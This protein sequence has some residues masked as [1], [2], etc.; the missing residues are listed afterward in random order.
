MKYYGQNETD[1][2]IAEFINIE[3]PGNC[4]EV[5]V[6][7]GSHGS[8]TKI[9]EDK[10]WD[11]LCIDPVPEHVE[12]ARSIRKN[13]VQC[14]CGD[15]NYTTNNF[16][17]FDIGKNNILSSLSGLQPD[18]ELLVSHGHL[19]NKCYKIKTEVKTL[20]TILQEQRWHR[21]IDF[22]SIDT[23]GTEL[24]VLKG[25][26]FSKRFISMLIIE[27]NH[28]YPEI[29]NYLQT[30]YFTKI[31][32]YYINDFYLHKSAWTNRRMKR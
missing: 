14:A 1:K 29:E 26:D 6:A 11:V 30:Y 31:K 23:E 2:I 7:D 24:D 8:N 21:Q 9:F 32:R 17:V 10:H 15:K 12:K 13:V 18:P 27:N 22:I 19:I 28:N 20:E 3:R 4:V 16:F 5:G 25:V